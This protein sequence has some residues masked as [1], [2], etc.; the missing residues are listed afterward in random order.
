MIVA[1]D[2]PRLFKIGLLLYGISFFLPS[3]GEFHTGGYTP[4][5]GCAYFTLSFSWEQAQVWIHGVPEISKPIDYFSILAI[6]W[7]NPIFVTAALL[8]A[9]NRLQRFTNILGTI[10]VCMMPLC[11]VVF[12]YHSLY[13][14]EGYFLWTIGML[15]VLFSKKSA[16]LEAVESSVSQT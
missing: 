9:K 7:M 8:L 12:L 10:L 16:S 4:G 5:Y 3:I 14:R 2:Q 15:Q 6:G 1:S 11:W 13:P